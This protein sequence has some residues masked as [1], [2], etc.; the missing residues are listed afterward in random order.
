ML[1][2][3]HLRG[4]KLQGGLQVE[5][6]ATFATEAASTN[7]DFGLAVLGD[8]QGTATKVTLSPSLGLVSIDATQQGNAQVRAGPLPPPSTSGWTVHAYVDHSI[9]EIIVNNITA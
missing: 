6:L 7:Q 5:I 4:P 3:Q 9:L 1:R 2:R 8:G